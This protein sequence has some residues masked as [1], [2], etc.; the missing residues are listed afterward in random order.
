MNLLLRR[1]ME[2]L[3]HASVGEG[4][5]LSGCGQQISKRRSVDDVCGVLSGAA[6]NPALTVQDDILTGP[7]GV[8]EM[9][10]VLDAMLAPFTEARLQSAFVRTLY[11][12]PKTKS[13]TFL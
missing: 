6:L 7:C 1:T 10:K 8:P 5:W 12:C 3:R 13:E 11:E 2:R 9:L 4:C